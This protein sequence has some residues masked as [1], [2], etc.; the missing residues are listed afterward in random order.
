MAELS[1]LFTKAGGM[2]RRELAPLRHCFGLDRMGS[3]DATRG[4]GGCCRR[5]V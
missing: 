2:A 1:L 4:V 3:A 5:I